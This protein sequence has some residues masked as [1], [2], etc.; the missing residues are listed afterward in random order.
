MPLVLSRVG[1]VAKAAPIEPTEGDPASIEAVREAFDAGL[2]SVRNAPTDAMIEDA[3]ERR[4]SAVIEGLPV[5]DEEY[6]DAV[7]TSQEALDAHLVT[8]AQV[9]LKR[10]GIGMRFD[11]D[12]PYAVAASRT[13]Y[14]RLAVGLKRATYEGIRAV[15]ERGFVEG[16][17]PREMARQLRALR[18]AIGL[19]RRRA[20]ALRNR[21][22]ALVDAGLPAERVAALSEAYGRKLLRQ[23]TETIARTET[24][25]TQNEGQL[26][27]WNAAKGEGYLL[28][29]SVKRW[30]AGARSDRTCP[31]CRSLH[32]QERQLDEPFTDLNGKSYDR[33]GAH[34]SC[35]CT[36][37]LVT[38][39]L[40]AQVPVEVAPLIPE[41]E[42]ATP[43]RQRAERDPAPTVP[44]SEQPVMPELFVVPAPGVTV[45]PLVGE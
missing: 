16:F 14:A 8:S 32:G 10:L 7:R 24:I 22:V 36:M 17:P 13:Q 5:W 33:P 29:Q 34:P 42:L 25:T 19:D 21:V 20:A 11:L 1:R 31:I 45:L 30:I 28:P 3:L 38:V 9:E 12:N 40:G 6:L 27:A 35:R 18:P 41:E 4:D 37:A 23:R 2:V 44:R 15:V 39:A 26:Q 43:G